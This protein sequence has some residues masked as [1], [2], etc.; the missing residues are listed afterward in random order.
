[1]SRAATAAIWLEKRERLRDNRKQMNELC[2]N[3]ADR[4]SCVA[5]EDMIDR[6]LVERVCHSLPS[7]PQIRKANVK[8]DTPLVS[9]IRSSPHFA[10]V[11]F[12]NFG[13]ERT[14]ETYDSSVALVQKSA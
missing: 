11:S 2:W 13:F 10:A 9:R 6:W 1:M 4:L 14:L 7:S 8:S 3:R 12:A 5:V